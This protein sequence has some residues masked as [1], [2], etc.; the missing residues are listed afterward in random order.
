MYSQERSIRR[1]VLVDKRPLISSGLKIRPIPE[2]TIVHLLG[3][4]H[5]P[6]G[7]DLGG[8]SAGASCE[9]RPVSPSQWFLIANEVWGADRHQAVAKELRPKY[10]SVDQSHGR[11]RILLEGKH[12]G[13]LLSK[14]SGADFS[15]AAFA[16]GKAIVTL[17]GRITIHVTR[18]DQERWEIIVLRTL[19]ESVYDDLI[20]MGAEFSA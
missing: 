2:G 10:S 19:A 5:N 1:D 20:Q 12:V 14:G 8:L 17:L 6:E 9:L 15:D 16:P 4:P 18:L 3:H 13:A 7:P 11:V